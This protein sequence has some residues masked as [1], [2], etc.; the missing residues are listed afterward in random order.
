MRHKR[1]KKQQGTLTIVNKEMAKPRMARSAKIA[2]LNL[3]T[4]RIREHPST[5]IPGTVDKIISISASRACQKKHR[6]LSIVPTKGIEI[7]ALKIR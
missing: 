3:D 2:E 5:T 6:F 1:A 4:S 7:S